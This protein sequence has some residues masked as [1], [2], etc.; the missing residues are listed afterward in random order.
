MRKTM[1][2]YMNKLRSNRSVT[3]Q[4]SGCGSVWLERCVR[5][6]E[7]GGSNPLTPTIFLPFSLKVIPGKK[8][9]TALA[10]MICPL[11]LFLFAL[12]FCILQKCGDSPLPALESPAACAISARPS[13]FGGVPS[14]ALRLAAGCA[15]ACGSVWLERCV[16]DAEAGGSNPLTPTIFLPKWAKKHEAVR[17]RFMARSAASCSVSC[18]SYF[19]ATPQ[20]AS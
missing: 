18:A 15:L 14:L 4:L 12:H 19:A 7:A 11:S 9:A 2:Y 5:D 20:N 8:Q 1:L 16:R 6:A 3:V 13:L 17:I 10:N